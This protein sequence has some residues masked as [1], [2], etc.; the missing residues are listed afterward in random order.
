MAKILLIEDDLDLCSMVADF[1]TTDRHTVEAVNDGQTGWEMLQNSVF[2]LVV[3]DWELPE[4]QGIEVLRRFRSGGGKTPVIMLTGKGEI[5]EKELGFETGADDYLSKPFE[6]RELGM[7][8]R[9]LLRRSPTAVSNELKLHDLVLDTVKHK[10]SKNGKEIKLLPRDFSLLEFFMRYPGEIFSPD[11]LLAR[12]W[13][14]DSDASQEG[15]RVAI[16]RIRKAI[17][18]SDDLTLSI[19]ENVPRVGYRLRA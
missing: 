15:L 14:Q 3:L 1:L 10:V 16:R 18:S 2:D 6:L 8:L 9:A 17:D 4:L 5:A 11:T 13:H 7:R 19:I 12:V